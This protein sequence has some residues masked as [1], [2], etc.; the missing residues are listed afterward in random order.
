MSSAGLKP[1]ALTFLSR[2]VTQVR[3]HG[4]RLLWLRYIR[5]RGI[6]RTA[7]VSCPAQSELEVHT[8]V[9]GRDWLNCIWTMKSFARFCARPFRLIIF[10]DAT[11]SREGV[12]NL[13]QHL[14]GAEVLSFDESLPATEKAFSTRY[15]ALYSL[16]TDG[17]FFTLPKVLDSFAHRR[18]DMVL[19]IDPDVLF[20]ECPAEMLDDL[21][22]ARKYFGRLNV[23]RRDSDPRGAFCIDAVAL[24]EQFGF[25]LPLRFNCGLGSFNYAAADWDLIERVV[26]ALRP[27]ASRAFMLDQTILGL[28]C[29]AR[30]WH[31]LPPERYVLEPVSYTHLTLP[32]ILRV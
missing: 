19:A 29:L 15:P 10:C 18:S 5:R 17:R 12:A 28:L 14:A 1:N 9:C 24:R 16:R 2:G 26:K 6:L 23:P 25:E 21:D 20:F 22:P 11:V 32:T 4:V 30:G 31:P 7:A 13:R 8:Q 3:R 27:D